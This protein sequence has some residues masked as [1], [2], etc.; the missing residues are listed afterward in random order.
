MPRKTTISKQ[1]NKKN[2]D[3]TSNEEKIGWHKGALTTLI[4]ERKE[5]LRL[6]QI[7]NS[8]I[9]AHAKALKELGIDLQKEAQ[10][11]AK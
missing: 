5:L 2:A 1:T 8:L 6:L 11:A 3:A 7:T 4:N 9:E 10:Q